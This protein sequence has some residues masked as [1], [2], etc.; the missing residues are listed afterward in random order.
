MSRSHIFPFFQAILAAL[1]FGMSAPLAKLLLGEMEPISLAGLLYLGSGLSLLVIKVCQPTGNRSTR[2]EAEIRKADLAW[3]AGAILAGGIAAP[4][5]LLFSLRN[6]P[7]ATAALLL[8]FEGVATTFIASLVF[9]EAISRRAWWAILSITF[10]SICLSI[11]PNNGWGLSL[12]ALGILAAC[13]LWGIDNNFTRN[14]SAK[15]P[16]TIVTVKG[17]VAGTFSVALT[18]ISGNRLPGFSIS[19]SAMALASSCRK[20]QFAP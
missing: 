6:T 4:I 13:I 8:N 1:L 7:A 10:A 14:I 18:M 19:I 2:A 9:K 15:D 20:M 12:G 3:L 17:L 5:I 16:L 11:K